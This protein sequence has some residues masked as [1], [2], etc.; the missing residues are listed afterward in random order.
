MVIDRRKAL[1]FAAA[2]ALRFLLFF[3]FPSLPDRLASR[4][5]I[6]TPVNSFKRC[7]LWLSLTTALISM[8]VLMLRF[9]QSKYKRDF[10]SILITSLHT[11]EVSSTRQENFQPE[12][13]GKILTLS[14][15]RLS[16]Y[17]YLRSF[18]PQHS[19]FSQA[20]SILWS[21]SFAQTA[22]SRL[23]TLAN[24]P[25]H[26]YSSLQGRTPNGIA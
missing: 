8:H 20:F 16:S 22:L 15:R 18:L 19:P 23:L 9:T 26:D 25:H 14:I 6:A 13:W 2:S 24:R 12:F 17:L 5:E 7:M 4:V 3:G 11:M 10:F 21:T 1:V